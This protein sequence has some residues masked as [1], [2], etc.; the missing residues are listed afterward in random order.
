MRRRLLQTL[1]AAY[2][3]VGGER[4]SAT[5]IVDQQPA[6]LGGYG[7]DTDFLNSFGDPTWQRVADNIRL[8]QSAVV[9]HLSWHG[10][11]GSDDQNHQP[12]IGSESLR[13]R[14]Y[15]SRAVDGLPD[16]QNVILDRTF[17]NLPRVATGRTIAV[18]GRPAEYFYEAD[19]DAEVSLLANTT[20]WLEIA[21]IGDLSSTFRWE[22]GF[23]LI[24]SSAFAGR[25]TAGQWLTGSGSLAFQLS[26]IPEPSTAAL[27]IS[28]LGLFLARRA[29]RRMPEGRRKQQHTSNNSYPIGIR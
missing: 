10:F 14:F 6:Q 13:V 9:R 2:V 15:G 4:T 8:S 3:V 1:I 19:L 17:V 11:Y 16:D 18:D 5:L 29:P 23:G 25:L 22:T 26:T 24:P 7:S 12:P 20:Y 28:A 27:L 21:Q